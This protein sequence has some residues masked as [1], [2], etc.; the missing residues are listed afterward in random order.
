MFACDRYGHPPNNYVMV[1][2]DLMRI[3]TKDF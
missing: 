3:F 1:T 2:T